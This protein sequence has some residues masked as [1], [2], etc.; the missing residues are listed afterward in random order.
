MR[1]TAPVFL[2]WLLFFAA[3]PSPA[4]AEDTMFEAPMSL[5]TNANLLW[6]LLVAGLLLVAGYLLWRQRQEA[7]RANLLRRELLDTQAALDEAELLL[8]ME[9]QILLV[10]RTAETA[11]AERSSPSGGAE[12]APEKTFIHPHLSGLLPEDGEPARLEDWL[13]ADSAH[14]LRQEL[15]K[16]QQEGT[17]F[18]I[19]VRTLSGELLEADGRV[20]GRY[21]MLRFR[22][23]FGE[24]LKALEETHDVRLLKDQARRITNLL[25]NAPVPVWITDGEGNLQWANHHW[26][27]LV[28]ADSLEVARGSGKTLLSAGEL[29]AASLLPTQGDWEHLLASTHIRG[30]RRHFEVW[31]KPHETGIV[32]WALEVSEREALREELEQQRKVQGRIFDQLRTAVAIFDANQRLVFHNTAYARLWDLDEAWLA[33]RPREEE[34][35]NRIYDRGR[36]SIMEDFPQWRQRWLDIYAEQKPRRARL[37]LAQGQVV[38]VIAE[39]QPGEGVI[40]MFEDITE[41]MRLEARYH[42]VMQVQEETLDH[43]REAVAVFGTDGRLK[44]FNQMFAEM[45]EL[46]E[47]RLISRPH[48]DEVMQ[49]CRDKAQDATFWEILKECVTSAQAERREKTGRM[50]LRDGRA[51]EYSIVPLPDGNSLAAWYDMTD[52]IRAE[53]AARER[54]AALEESDR[55]KTAF[56]NSISYEMRTPLTSI[57]GFAGLLQEGIA[58]EINPRQWQYLQDIQEASDELLDKIDAALDLAAYDAGKLE[59][60]LSRFEV[61]PML[62]ELAKKIS[63]RLERRNMRLEVMVAEDVNTIS[64]DRKRLMQMLQHLLINAIGFGPRNSVVQLGVQRGEGGE[65]LFWVADEGPGMNPEMIQRAFERFFAR[66]SPE[67]HRGPGLGLPLVKALAQL[68]GGDVELRSREGQG[69][70]VICRLPQDVEQAREN[71]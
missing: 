24:R 10:W 71:A 42:E 46:D 60:N 31:L 37:T 57:T 8:M 67:G 59:L 61:L 65:V 35:L 68:H 13:E 45:W 1:Q 47:A 17:A 12:K 44:L 16:L 58:G 66:P 41:Q 5:L 70:T 56:L 26:L 69:T 51:F 23:L 34:I 54:V 62:E 20:S 19:S 63:G 52:A 14:H 50:M 3:A 64:A 33:R 21:L 4:S 32:H 11:A 6:P 38:D 43:L 28:E 36:L 9:P 53:R 48:V 29:A 27:E 55:V 22:Q 25:T 7:R 39:P 40:Y 2:A 49:A 15:R 18:N 30:R